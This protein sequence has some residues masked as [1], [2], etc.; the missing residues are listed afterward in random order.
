[1][2]VCLWKKYNKQD[3][4]QIIESIWYKES[5]MFN[6]MLGKNYQ[7]QFRLV[8]TFYFKTKSLGLRKLDPLWNR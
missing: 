1:M 8:F 5:M 7:F 3:D 6:A 4:Y 2:E